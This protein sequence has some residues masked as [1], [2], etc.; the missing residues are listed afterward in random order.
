MA[1]SCFWSDGFWLF[2]LVYSKN[3]KTVQTFWLDYSAH[4]HQKGIITPDS[5]VSDYIK[6]A[7]EYSVFFM[8][9]KHVFAQNITN[10]PSHTLILFVFLKFTNALMIQLYIYI[11]WL[12]IISKCQTKSGNVVVQKGRAR[13]CA[14]FCYLWWHHQAFR[15]HSMN[16]YVSTASALQI[17]D[18]AMVKF[19]VLTQS[20]FSI[21]S[22][23]TA[24]Q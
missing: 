22:P 8:K 20:A 13:S 9:C 23:P 16:W 12:Q 3:K 2:T 17:L 21:S 1:A 19:S 15:Q 11:N 14:S 6:F 4:T 24:L 5:D 7:C 10:I 18:L